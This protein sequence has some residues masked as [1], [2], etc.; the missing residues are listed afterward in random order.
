MSVVPTSHLHSPSYFVSEKFN[1]LI[2][3]TSQGR[4]LFHC[5]TTH[6]ITRTF[7]FFCCG[8]W[9]FSE[10]KKSKRVSEVVQ[11]WFTGSQVTLIPYF[12]DIIGRYRSFIKVWALGKLTSNEDNFTWFDHLVESFFLRSCRTAENVNETL[13]GWGRFPFDQKFRDFRFEIEWNGKNSGK[14]FRKFRNMFRVY[15]ICW[16]FRNYRKFCVPFVRDVR[17]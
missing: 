1:V 13:G 6:S 3:L 16:N 12:I 9:T 5:Y 8:L 2:F 17:V 15:P 14:S 11:T 10:K 7:S 4:R